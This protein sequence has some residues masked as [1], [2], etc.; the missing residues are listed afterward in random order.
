MIR[1]VIS[2]V[3]ANA[4]TLSAVL[5]D[6]A[7]C[8]AEGVVCLG[9]VVGYGPEPAMSISTLRRIAAITVAGN[10][11][12][13]VSGRLGTEDFID[14]AADAAARHR[15]AI[16]AE[17]LEWLRSLPYVFVGGTFACAH[18][19]FTAPESF[20][21]VTDESEALANF[22][23]R[24]EQL[25]FV[26][27]SHVPGIFVTGASGRAHQLPPADFTLET[28]KRYIVN[29]G[30][31]GY[32]RTN[33]S[34]CEATYVLY[35]DEERTVTFR[36]IPFS[37]RSVMQTGRN[38]KRMKWR[39]VAAIAATAALAAG[40][41][42]WLFSPSGRVETVTKVVAMANTDRSESCSIPAGASKLRVEVKL[43][44]GSPAAQLRLVFTNAA[45]DTLWE[46]RWTAKRSKKA[47]VRVPPG[48]IRATLSAGRVS[49]STPATFG[50]F[51]L[52]PL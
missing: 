3:H 36:R 45:G 47:T 40:A 39:T 51:S 4:I 6:A 49:G 41:T 24:S 10:H 21:Y 1:A 44:K 2:D 50:E 25:L 11:D 37:V 33:G 29:P 26:G 52:S 16:S 18:G 43:A 5:E 42:A 23:V 12:D 48:S 9:D 27:H 46:E 28:G 7:N 14:L 35:D 32:P 15:E 30:S 19:D 17:S 20:R 22:A 13:A 31:V 8:G 38:P 34:T